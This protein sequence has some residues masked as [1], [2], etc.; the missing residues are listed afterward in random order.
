VL[1]DQRRHWPII[2]QFVCREIRGKLFFA[3]IVKDDSVP[4][5]TQGSSYDLGNS[6]IE[7]LSAGVG[8]N[9]KY[10]HIGSCNRPSILGEQIPIPP[11]HQDDTLG[12]YEMKLASNS[13]AAGNSK[14]HSAGKYGVGLQT[15]SIQ[16]S[17]RETLLFRN[18]SELR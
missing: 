8:E 16:E 1:F 7:T 18:I 13:A 5:R 14:A 3:E 9:D 2:R 15:L 10:V 17:L 12:I 6:V 4:C 11:Q